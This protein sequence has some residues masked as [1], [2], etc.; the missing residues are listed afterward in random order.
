MWVWGRRS[1]GC[2]SADAAV[3]PVVPLMDVSGLLR[4]KKAFAGVMAA[5]NL[6]DVTES[7][8]SLLVMRDRVGVDGLLDWVAPWGCGWVCGWVEVQ[9][10]VVAEV[11]EIEIEPAMGTL[12]H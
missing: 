4:F 5:D 9:E 12:I 8:E 2:T 7:I 11:V 3:E 10:Q 1:W 6:G